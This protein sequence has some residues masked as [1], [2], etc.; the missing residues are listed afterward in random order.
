MKATPG[1]DVN[2]NTKYL[3]F[4]N[5]WITVNGN[6]IIYFYSSSNLA[7]TLSGACIGLWTGSQNVPSSTDWYGVGMNAGQILNVPSG[8]FHSFQVDGTQIAK[9]TSTGITIGSLLAAT[10]SWIQSQ[11]YL[12]TTA[13]F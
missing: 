5:G 8:Q 2:M 10:Q 9:I 12:T 11:S 3:N 7:T 1:V 6:G 13:A 4:T